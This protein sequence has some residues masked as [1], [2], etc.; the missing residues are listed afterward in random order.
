MPTRE[1]LNRLANVAGAAI[2]RRSWELY[3]PRYTYVTSAGTVISSPLER[4][5]R[6]NLATNDDGSIGWTIEYEKDGTVSVEFADRRKPM[7]E[8]LV[9][10][11]TVA[12][13]EFLQGF[14]VK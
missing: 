7:E 9:S 6:Y 8:E 11:D 2:G 14:E 10:G 1:Q 5:M 4:W 12:L 3:E 13:D